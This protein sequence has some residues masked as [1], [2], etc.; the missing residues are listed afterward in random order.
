MKTTRNVMNLLELQTCLVKQ[1]AELICRALLTAKGHHHLQI[2]KRMRMA[3]RLAR[4]Q[5]DIGD[6]HPAVLGH[7]RAAIRQDLDRFLIIPV[8]QHALYEIRI[9]AWSHVSEEV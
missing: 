1:S 6:E 8:V 4:L 7:R 9:V 5:D 3:H 2:D